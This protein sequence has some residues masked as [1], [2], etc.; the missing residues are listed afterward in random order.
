MEI[1]GLNQ[2]FSI[3]VHLR[4]APRLSTMG[5][6]SETRQETSGFQPFYTAVAPVYESS[7]TTA[8]SNN[9][10]RI[11]V[12]YSDIISSFGNAQGL[13]LTL[14]SVMSSV[15]TGSTCMGCQD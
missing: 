12:L 3:F 6:Q 10:Y 13:L 9:L 1:P 2:H 5:Q 11:L 7:S 15:I 4:P 14:H 8:R